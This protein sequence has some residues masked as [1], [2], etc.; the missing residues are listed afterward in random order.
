MNARRLDGLCPAC[1]WQSLAEGDDEEAGTPP[2]STHTTSLLAIPGHNVLEEVARG[3]M[4]IVYRARQLEP[5]RLVALK[6]LLPHQIGSSEMAA[7]FRLEARTLAGLDHPAI[8]P[9][10]HFGEQ[11]GLP[12]F[13]MKLATGGTLAQRKPGYAGNWRAVATLV[14]LLADAVQFAHERG[15][16]HRDLKP[17]N[18]LFDDAG[19]AYVSDFGLAKL[20]VPGPGTPALTGSM[21]L[22]GTPQYLAPEVASSSVYNA[23]VASDV[24]ALGAILYELITG[25]A[26][27]EESSLTALL[28]AISDR[29]PAPPSR[30]APGLPRDLEVI[31]LKCIAREPAHRYGSAREFVEDLRRFLE[32]RPITARPVTPAERLVQWTR[33]NPALAGVS[34]ALLAAVLIGGGALIERNLALQEALAAAKTAGGEALDNLHASL[35][36]QA[37]A[38]RSS[39][40][41]GQRHQALVSLTRAAE[42]RKTTEL[43]SE[44][45]AALALPD[46][47]L[48]RTL[49]TRLVTETGTMDFSPDLASYLIVRSNAGFELRRT[50]DGSVL[51]EF[52]GPT[53][54]LAQFIRLSPDGRFASLTFL[55]GRAEV[56]SLERPEWIWQRPFPRPH[57]AVIALASGGVFAFGE[58]NGS[59]VMNDTAARQP[60]PVA[61]AG[62]TVLAA[63]F[64]PEGKRIAVVRRGSVEMIDSAAGKRLWEFQA[65][66]GGVEPAWSRDGRHVAVANARTYEIHILDSEQGVVTRVLHGHTLEPRFLAFHPGRDRLVS[67]GLD[68]TLRLWDTLDGTELLQADAAPRALRISPDGKLVGAAPTHIQA[69]VFELAPEQVFG[70]WRGSR[71]GTQTCCWIDRSPD[72]RFVATCDFEQVRLWDARAREEV[73]SFPFTDAAWTSVLFEPGG[74]ALI[75]SGR[76]AGI[77]RRSLR[78]RESAT[79]G[80]AEVEVGPEAPLGPERRGFLT[81]LGPK[82]ASWLIHRTDQRKIVVWPGGQPERERTVAADLGF[83]LTAMSPDA[84]WVAS[85][86][87][88]LPGVEV[89]DALSAQSVAKLPVKRH[90]TARFSPDGRWLLTG[91]DEEYRLWEAGSWEPRLA[92]P[93]SLAG[94]PFGSASFST[95]G[96]WVAT[97]QGRDQ[98]E[99]RDTTHFNALITLEPPRPLRQQAVDWSP[100]DGR[101]IILG[102][103]HR[104]FEWDLVALRADLTKLGLDWKDEAKP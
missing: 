82:G 16:L 86:A 5:E 58:T 32:R 72:G 42:I 20:M 87:Y 89:W 95:T 8:L 54:D 61:E 76:M 59:V 24:Y 47:Q 2:D 68:R 83:Y 65:E 15:V 33:R 67:V 74:K 25:R 90:A 94:E 85:I 40:R 43:R 7:R 30:F 34:A 46:L 44:A 71:L 93:A 9:V 81:D 103:R 29:D 22:L 12:Y 36:A 63:S 23:T 73:A 50:S 100:D 97:H 70:E 14:A 84:R 101:F 49:P 10:Y 21:H 56:W 75:Y 4:G 18:V 6:M 79:G 19:R 55:D 88:P 102:A 37:R 31:C 77:F 80:K 51:K 11:D 52:A 60:R 66:L 17:G 57:R 45:A 92:W 48:L 78:W 98:F 41:I 91:T 3:G 64:D 96:R 62:A 69:G 13:T 53:N 35:I 1:T 38:K 26:P 39:G 27:Y 28:K 99:L 104:V